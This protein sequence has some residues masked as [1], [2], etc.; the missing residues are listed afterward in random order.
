MSPRW[1]SRPRLPPDVARRRADPEGA[2]ARVSRWRRPVGVVPAAMDAVSVEQR[3]DGLGEAGDRAR[4]LDL[5]TVEVMRTL[6]GLSP[7]TS[8]LV[9]TYLERIGRPL[10]DLGFD[11]GAML[12]T[13]GYAAHLAVEADHAAYGAADVPVIGGLPPARDGRAPADLL[14]RVVRA[15]RRGFGRLRA[16]DDE[17]WDGFV[18]CSTFRVHRLA[19]AAGAA[20]EP[21]GFVDPVVVE[22]LVRLGWILRQVDLHYG[23]QPD[24]R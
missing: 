13:R 10:R 16:V 24:R 15:T 11:A 2:A 23:Q 9:E 19:G 12:V 18:A 8:G 7:L 4:A 1:G 21:V 6:A 20:D 14:T 3:L 17:V 22:A 5:A